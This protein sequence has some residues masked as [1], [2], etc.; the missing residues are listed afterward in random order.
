LPLKSLEMDTQKIAK[1][2]NEYEKCIKKLQT[3]NKKLILIL[4]KH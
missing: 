4:D 2:I 3:D 1:D